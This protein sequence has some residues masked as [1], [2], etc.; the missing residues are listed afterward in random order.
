MAAI[1]R[2]QG[3]DTNFD[4]ELARALVLHEAGRIEEAHAIAAALQQARPQDRSIA[5]YAAHLKK[6]P[7]PSPSVA[8]AGQK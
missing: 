4:A 8:P 3:I 1:R 6:H 2:I 5:R 7:A